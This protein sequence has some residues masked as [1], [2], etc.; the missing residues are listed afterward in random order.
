MCTASE[1]GCGGEAFRAHR[2]ETSEG[3]CRGQRYRTWAN[4]MLL[5]ASRG[6][7]DCVSPGYRGRNSGLWN[8]PKGLHLF[9]LLSSY[10][11][12]GTIV[13]TR[14]RRQQFLPSWSLHYGVMIVTT[15]WM[16][17]LGQQL[18]YILRCI[19]SLTPHC[20]LRSILLLSLSHWWGNWG[21]EV[22]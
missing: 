18:H 14:W 10:H 22:K 21:L 3:G 15:Y 16:L 1:L 2:A 19:I 6:G 5:A 20:S 17:N 8:G 4:S 13:G 9:K 12:P 7:R 11:L